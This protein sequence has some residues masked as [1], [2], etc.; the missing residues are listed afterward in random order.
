MVPLEQTQEGLDI[1]NKNTQLAAHYFRTAIKCGC[2]ESYFDLAKLFE[3]GKLGTKVA[4]VSTLFYERAKA[5]GYGATRSKE[6]N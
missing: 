5:L 6:S 1:K 3:S 2:A 4:S